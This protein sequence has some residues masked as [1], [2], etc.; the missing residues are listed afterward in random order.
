MG[1]SKRTASIS[2][3]TIC[4]AICASPPNGPDSTELTSKLNSLNFRVL[5]V[6]TIV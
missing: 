6:Q 5:L 4:A 1:L 2:L 3:L